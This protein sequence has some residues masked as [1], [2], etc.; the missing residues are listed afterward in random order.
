MTT[1]PPP[2]LRTNKSVN[3]ASTVFQLEDAL[4]EF[5]L[6]QTNDYLFRSNEQ[7]GEMVPP[8]VWSGFIPRNEAGAVVPGDITTYPA[9]ILNARRGTQ[10]QESEIAEVEVIVGVFDDTPDQQGYRDVTNI[11]QRLKDRLR[12]QDIIREQFPLRMP[13]KWEI[14]R[15]YGGASTNYF[16]YFFGELLLCFELPVPKSQYEES[17]LSGETNRGRFNEFPIPSDEQPSPE[18]Y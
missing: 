7:T 1:Y 16:P 3:A 12:E 10:S 4:V 13:L 6:Q 15:F 17:F 18:S 2:D 11:V 14:N 9:I 8:R 5:F